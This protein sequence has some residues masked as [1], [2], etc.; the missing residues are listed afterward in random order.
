MAPRRLKRIAVAAW[1]GI[2][3]LG[4]QALVPVLLAAEIE[5]ATTTTG[6]SVFT[7]CAFGHIH[8]VAHPAA[9]GKAPASSDDEDQDQGTVCPI[10]IALQATP[11]FTAPVQIALPV[12][13]G[14]PLVVV[15]ASP[16]PA[17]AIAAAAAYR[18]R[19]PPLG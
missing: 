3:A 17:P 15:V 4:I 11:P 9:D 1:L 18:S 10:C 12:P 19:A 8:A 6:K 5:I 13:S 2:L 16:A 14:H 7:L